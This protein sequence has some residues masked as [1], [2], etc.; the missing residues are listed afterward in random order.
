MIDKNFLDYDAQSRTWGIKESVYLSP[1]AN[2]FTASKH[3]NL[4]LNDISYMRSQE[5]VLTYSQNF[6]RKASWLELL[7][8]KTMDRIYGKEDRKSMKYEGWR[9]SALGYEE[10]EEEED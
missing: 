10:S 7:H 5:E 4:F 9:R 8:A 2:V 6:A 3:T 1:Y